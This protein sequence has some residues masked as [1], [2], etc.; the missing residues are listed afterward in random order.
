[1]L[2][3]F[4]YAFGLFLCYIYAANKTF[5]CPPLLGAND[6]SCSFAATFSEKITRTVRKF[7]PHLAAKMRPPHM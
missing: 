6:F 3:S 4:V 2:L 7:S 5:G 1:M